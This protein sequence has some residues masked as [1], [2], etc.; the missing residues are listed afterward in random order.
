MSEEAA[1]D[2]VE[3]LV[4]NILSMC[5]SVV[6]DTPITKDSMPGQADKETNAVMDNVIVELLL[7]EDLEIPVFFQTI[8]TCEIQESKT[9]WGRCGHHRLILCDIRHHVEFSI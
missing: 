5:S 8:V 9:Y 2:F 3:R 1:E 4:I 6:I 7:H